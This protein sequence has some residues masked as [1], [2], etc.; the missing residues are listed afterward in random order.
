MGRSRDNQTPDDN[1]SYIDWSDDDLDDLATITPADIADA[2]RDA[3]KYTDLDE[4][5]NADG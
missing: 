1:E 2:R 4:L 5:L 3:E